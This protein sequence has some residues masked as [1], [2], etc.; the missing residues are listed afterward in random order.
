MGRTPLRAHRDAIRSSRNQPPSSKSLWGRGHL[1]PPPGN[2]VHLPLLAPFASHW[3]RLDS[4]GHHFPSTA[5]GLNAHP[6][7]PLGYP[8]L[9]SLPNRTGAF[10]ILKSLPLSR[11]VRATSA[12]H[13]LQAGPHP[14]PR[15][16]CLKQGPCSTRGPGSRQ[17]GAPPP[18]NLRQRRPLRARLDLPPTPPH[19]APHRAAP[20]AIWP[21]GSQLSWKKGSG[22]TAG[23]KTQRSGSWGTSQDP[24]HTCSRS[25]S[26]EKLRHRAPMAD[27][28]DAEQTLSSGAVGQ[29]RVRPG[30]SLA[31]VLGNSV[32]RRG[33]HTSE[34][35]R[36]CGRQVSPQAPPPAPLIGWG[37]TCR[38]QPRNC[39]ALNFLH[40]CL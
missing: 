27:P 1:G 3:R 33:S 2:L 12:P 21:S 9:R 19:S 5:N 11:I 23:R 32:V 20:R 15:L 30:R 13:L 31:E 17:R 34:Q 16:L 39:R 28:A 40:P 24:P 14:A 4:S 26:A 7:T 8:N 22:T 37:R 29:G 35:R 10:I 25:R 6:Q 18:G 38:W 36:G